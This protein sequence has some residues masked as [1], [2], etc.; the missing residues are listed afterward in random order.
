MIG[1]DVSDTAL[2]GNV[3]QGDAEIDIDDF[4]NPDVD[5]RFTN[6]Y[7]LDAG[8]TR[9]SMSWNNI[10]VSNGAFTTGSDANQIQGKFYGPNH[11]EVGGIFERNNVVGAFGAKR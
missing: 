8:N 7:D 6:I 3:I 2:F 5:I 1:G 9:A 4:N 10:S 11:E